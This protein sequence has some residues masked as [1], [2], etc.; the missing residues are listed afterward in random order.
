MPRARSSPAW[1]ARRRRCRRGRT[2][3]A[4]STQPRRAGPDARRRFHRRRRGARG[5]PGAVPRAPL[6]QR[7]RGPPRLRQGATS[8]SGS[9]TSSAATIRP[10]GASTRRSSRRCRTPPR[11][12]SSA[13]SAR[14]GT[15]ELQAALVAIDPH[16]GNVLALVGGRDYQRSAFNRAS[17]SRR[18]PG[19]AFKPFVFAAALERGMSPVSTLTGLDRIPPQ[20][21]DEW[22]PR[23][24]RDDAPDALTLRAALIESNNRAATLLQQQVGSRQ[25]LALASRAGLE[26]LPD[27]PSLALGTGLVTPLAMTTAFAMFPNG[28]LAV[29]P[30]DITRV[31]DADGSHGVTPG[32]SRPSGSC[33]PRSRSR[34]S[35][36]W[37]TS[38][39]AA[40]ASRF[41]G[42]ASA[43]RSAAR[44][45]RPTTSR[46]PGSSASRRR[47]SSA[48][49][50]ASISRRRSA[51]TP[52]DRATRCRSGP[53]S[54][55]AR[56][57]SGR[58]A[59]SSGRQAS[60]TRR[61]ARSPTSS[62]WTAVRSTPSTSRKA[63][64]FR[65]AL[66]P[67]HRGTFRQ[68][69]ARTVDGWMSAIGRRVRDI[70][71]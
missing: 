49:G 11:R 42:W 68:R 13:G 61:C 23:N 56:R 21:P 24:V 45:A 39:I 20:G 37:G 3:T 29:R 18:Q 40:P 38:S 43:F 6:S 27:V 32:R 4:P 58:Q 59:A 71:R 25:V 34:W 47:S 2:S 12:R 1:P 67:L 57:R 5:A 16:T 46:T 62:R 7:R 35:R 64:R 52:T 36:C 66:C 15:P 8:A 63:T 69:V 17:R 30:R 60:T 53:T 54:C 14:L 55:S 9:A 44:P 28:G 26:D 22:T 70:F 33:R 10:T 48:C 51:P 19:S 65:I 50:S 41:G 31:R